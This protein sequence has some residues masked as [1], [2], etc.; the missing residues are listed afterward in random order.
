VSYVRRDADT[1]QILVCRPP[2]EGSK[3]TEIILC[4]E[5]E[6]TSSSESSRTAN[7]FVCAWTKDL[8]TGAPLLCMGGNTA[9]IKIINALTGKLHRVSDVN[10]YS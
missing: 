2:V 1:L 5:D 8:E 10:K 9:A 3:S 4:V 7:N 6:D